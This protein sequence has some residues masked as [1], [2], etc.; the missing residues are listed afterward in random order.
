MKKIILT[1]CL[2]GLFIFTSFS[3]GQAPNLEWHKSIQGSGEEAHGHYIIACSDGGYLQ[4]GETGF[5][6][7]NSAKILIVKTDSNGD[8][9]WTRTFGG[10]GTDLAMMSIKRLMLDIYWL[11]TPLPL[12][13][14]ATISTW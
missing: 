7:N 9:L 12:V 11:E 5:I 6:D 14:A 3:F 10:S 2:L 8:T 4:V 1:I 13:R